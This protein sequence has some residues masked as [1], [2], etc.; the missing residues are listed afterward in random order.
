MALSGQTVSTKPV[1]GYADLPEVVRSIV[2]DKT[3]C[4][5]GQK[6]RKALLKK[7]AQKGLD[8]VALR[9][10][11]RSWA[12]RTLE[13]HCT[14]RGGTSG[15]GTEP[16]ERLPLTPS[17]LRGGFEGYGESEVKVPPSNPTALALVHKRDETTAH[18]ATRDALVDEIKQMSPHVKR[19]PRQGNFLLFAQRKRNGFRAT[20]SQP[21]R[22]MLMEQRTPDV[23]AAAQEAQRSMRS[24]PA[25]LRTESFRDGIPDKVLLRKERDLVS[26]RERRYA[27]RLVP[28][29]LQ[30]GLGASAEAVR[31]LWRSLSKAHRRRVET[32]ARRQKWLRAAQLLVIYFDL[33]SEARSSWSDYRVLDDDEPFDDHVRATSLRER[34]SAIGLGRPPVAP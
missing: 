28:R 26:D 14:P 2:T 24:A 20:P 21:S 22:L 8:V 31:E 11:A 29:K 12:N 16:D 1:V 9:K 19:V 6:G 13:E 5:C 17:H 15:G 23:P 25:V 3:Y 34:A 18:L 10:Y 33:R 30:L 32:A 7:C 27:Q 4:L